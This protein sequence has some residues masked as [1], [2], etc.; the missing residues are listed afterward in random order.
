MNLM[1]K[2]NINPLAVAN[3]RQVDWNGLT[4]DVGVALI[5][6][7]VFG[8]AQP[9]SLPF[10]AATDIFVLVNHL[11]D[12][13]QITKLT[14][15]A[16]VK[17]WNAIADEHH[18]GWP[19]VKAKWNNLLTTYEGLREAIQL[20]YKRA[21]ARL[22]RFGELAQQKTIFFIDKVQDW[23]EHGDDYM[24]NIDNKIT[25]WADTLSSNI[26]KSISKWG[27]Y[28]YQAAISTGLWIAYLILTIII[29]IA[30]LAILISIAEWKDHGSDCSQ[31]LIICTGVLLIAGGLNYN[32]WIK[33]SKMNQIT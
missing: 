24:L 12:L 27:G 33:Q 28:T 14:I 3:E 31:P 21:S 7:V 10:L 13:I 2:I 22:R 8:I 4:I 1:N 30:T 25:N 5:S 23:N 11:G 29:I 15:R 18:A 19:N 6:T 16:G 9:E 17:I 26:D 20:G 32:I